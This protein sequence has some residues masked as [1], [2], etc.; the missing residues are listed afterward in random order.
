[1]DCKDGYGI[2]KIDTSWDRPGSG[3]TLL[4]EEKVMFLSWEMLITT[5]AIIYKE[6]DTRL[7]LI[8]NHYA[9][10]KLRQNVFSMPRKMVLMIPAAQRGHNILLR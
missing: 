7:W 9:E 1:V 8:I 3:F 2:L 4:F 6:H 10:Q 5:L